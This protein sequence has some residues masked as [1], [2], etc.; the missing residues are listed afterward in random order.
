MISTLLLLFVVV[1]VGIILAVAMLG[2]ED[3]IVVINNC[4]EN[5][6]YIG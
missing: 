5:V 4:N 1:V 3:R 2:V 6:I